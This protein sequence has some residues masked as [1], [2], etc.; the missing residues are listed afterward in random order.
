MKFKY[1]H[2]FNYV[3]RNINLNLHLCLTR[4]LV[5]KFPHNSNLCAFLISAIGVTRYIK[6]RFEDISGPNTE[7]NLGDAAHA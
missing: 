6:G 2:A 7:I 3:Q 1:R 5:S 4:C